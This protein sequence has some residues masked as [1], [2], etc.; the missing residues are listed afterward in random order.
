MQQG[1]RKQLEDS[2]RAV[3]MGRT[4]APPVDTSMTP[5]MP[6][7]QPI[8]L[9]A[10]T[11]FADEPITAGAPF[12]AGPGPSFTPDTMGDDMQRLKGYIPVIE[13]VAQAQDSPHVLR[14]FV[15]YLKSV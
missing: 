9:S 2:Q 10:P 15:L 5:P 7:E 14:D 13:T 6:M 11:Q 1:M 4:Q 12:G 8:P 3:P